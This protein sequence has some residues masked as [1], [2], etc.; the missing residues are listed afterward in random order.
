MPKIRFH[1]VAALLVLAAAT[2]WVATG[3]FSSV[4]SAA[5][6]APPPPA[7]RTEARD[8]PVRT[9]AVVEPPRVSH[10]RAIR[11][12]GVTAADKSAD[13]AIRAG[14]IVDELPVGKGDRVEPG[15]LILRL[16]AEEKEAAVETARQL[17][18]QREAEWEATERLA[19][20]GTIGKLQLD[21]ARSA[22]AAARS[23]LEAALAE[24]AR[25]EVRA[26]FAGIVDRVHVERGSA[27]LQGATVATI[28]NLDPTVA[29]GEVSETEL[30]HVEIGDAAEIRLVDGRLLQGSIR[31]I[32]KKA[33]EQTRT[34][35]VEIA[36]PN[37]DFAVPAGM[38][39]EITLRG[40]AVDAILLPRSVITLGAEG[41][42]GVRTVDADGTVR[43]HPI[44]LVDD[45]GKA[46]VLA[47][48]PAGERVIVAGQDLVE[49]GSR[50]NAVPAD[51]ATVNDLLRQAHAEGAR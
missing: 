43:F 33:S 2:A 17:V 8:V 37:A 42:L 45:T 20:S 29:I 13:L 14:G 34:F 10:A 41:E 1:K 26:P 15:D 47:G 40:D 16:A 31:Y 38:T 7:E 25:N 19:R 9:V 48:I 11:I 5:D 22:L 6:D 28:L 21:N 49:E 27:V 18:A 36:A 51:P 23:Q 39:A 44:D 12:P 46:L 35:R 30:G 24:L 3:R 50:V 32:S 4:G